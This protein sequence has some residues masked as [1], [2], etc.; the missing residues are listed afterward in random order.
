MAKNIKPYVDPA[1]ERAKKLINFLRC[2]DILEIGNG[3]FKT[4]IWVSGTSYERNSFQETYKVSGWLGKFYKKGANAMRWVNPLSVT[5][6]ITGRE[7]N[8]TVHRENRIRK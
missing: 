6:T 8:L 5:A 4:F 3:R 2:G 1:T 7:K